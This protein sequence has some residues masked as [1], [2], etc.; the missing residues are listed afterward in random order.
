MTSGEKKKCQAIIHAASAGAATVGAGFAQLP[1][2]DNAVIVPM[3][4]AMVISLGAVYGVKL[5]ES[6]AKATL[7]T[8][9]ATMVGRSISQFLLGWIPG[10]GN[11]L[12]ASTAAGVTEVIGWA[13]AKDFDRNHRTLPYG[14]S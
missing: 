8:A 5:T 7:A 11:V 10:F 2:S 4:V 6:A 1:G 9:T 3:Q 12:N 14:Q 13:V